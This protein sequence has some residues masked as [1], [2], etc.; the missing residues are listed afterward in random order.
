M[1]SSSA[2]AAPSSVTWLDRCSIT[3]WPSRR[4]TLAVRRSNG[5]PRSMVFSSVELWVERPPRHRVGLVL[6]VPLDV[7]RPQPDVLG[8]LAPVV[9]HPAGPRRGNDVDLLQDLA[10]QI[11]V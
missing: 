11:G 2:A 7:V 8:Q 1:R 9:Q 10:E 6:V 3:S 5:N 4:C